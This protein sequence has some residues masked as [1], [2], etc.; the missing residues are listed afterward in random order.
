MAVRITVVAAL[1]VAAARLLGIGGGIVVAPLA[2]WRAAMSA[3][4]LVTFLWHTG[5]NL[6]CAHFDEP[7]NHWKNPD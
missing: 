4:L 5:N 7:K 3:S 6:V 1:L 2:A